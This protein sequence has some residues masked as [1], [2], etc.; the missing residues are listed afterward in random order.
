M[1]EQVETFTKNAGVKGGYVVVDNGPLRNLSRSQATQVFDS[2][3]KDCT[4]W[5]VENGKAKV[6]MSK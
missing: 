6:V 5:R 4:V 2:T 1:K 3:T